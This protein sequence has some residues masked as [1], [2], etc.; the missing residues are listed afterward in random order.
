MRP[1]WRMACGGARAHWLAS[2]VSAFASSGTGADKFAK[3]SRLSV[4]FVSAH[5]DVRRRAGAGVG[6]AGHV[7]AGS[8]EQIA[9]RSGVAVGGIDAGRKRCQLIRMLAGAD[10]RG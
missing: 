5:V 1:S 10:E 6:D 2:L 9:R 4:E 3:F 8:S 7:E